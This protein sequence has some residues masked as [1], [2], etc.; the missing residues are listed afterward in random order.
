MSCGISGGKQVIKIADTSNHGRVCL[1]SQNESTIFV[2]AKCTVR[3][4]SSCTSLLIVVRTIRSVLIRVINKIGR[5]R[6]GSPICFLTS[7]ITDRIG[8]HQVL[9]PINHNLSKFLK[10]GS[11]LNQ[12]TR[13]SNFFLLAV[14]KRAI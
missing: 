5:P 7:M 8:R 12:N 4:F 2:S 11:F 10:K 14:K 3:V 1:S 6:S 13:N 9:L